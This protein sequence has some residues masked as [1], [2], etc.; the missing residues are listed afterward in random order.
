MTA[1]LPTFRL[2]SS[3][4]SS[5]L[6]TSVPS[7][8]PAEGRPM[9]NRSRTP[10]GALVL[11]FVS[12]SM[13]VACDPTKPPESPNPQEGPRSTGLCGDPWGYT[14]SMADERQVFTATRLA[15]GTV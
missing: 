3:P 4:P 12:C 9:L 1:G 10:A 2:A 5:A 13:F 7:H 8:S 6:A 15:N 14:G 11:L